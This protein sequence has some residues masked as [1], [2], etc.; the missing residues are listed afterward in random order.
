M[1]QGKSTEPTIIIKFTQLPWSPAR[2]F[3]DKIYWKLMANSIAVVR[4]MNDRN[5]EK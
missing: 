4:T 5:R 1:H 3:R 2:G